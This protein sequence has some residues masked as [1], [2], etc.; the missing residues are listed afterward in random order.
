MKR[1]KNILLL[2]A[3]AAM[4]AGLGL[5]LAWATVT[6]T[7]IPNTITLPDGSEWEVLEYSASRR[8]YRVGEGLWIDQDY[9]TNKTR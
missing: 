8:A 1:T 5:A 3:G 6:T 4:A 9:I 2:W 7:D